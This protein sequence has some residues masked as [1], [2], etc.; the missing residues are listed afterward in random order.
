MAC[1]FL[2][3]ASLAQVQEQFWRM[4]VRPNLGFEYFQR[5]VDLFS[6]DPDKEE[7]IKDEVS[8]KLKS[9]FI[10]L[11]IGVELQEGFYLAPILGY[12]V[13]NHGDLMFRRLP[14][15]VELGVGGISGVLFGGEIEKRLLTLRDVELGL[16]GQFVYY[17]GKEETWDVPGL[18]VEGDVTG[19][20]FWLRGLVGPFLIYR[21][22]YDF[23]PY[24]RLCYSRHWGKFKLEQKIG[25]LNR[26]EEKK[27]IGKSQISL[28]LG[29]SYEITPAFHVSGE[30]IFMPYK[31][32]V[33]SGLAVKV[34]YAF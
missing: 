14:F 12:S 27:M 10:T 5:E 29:A 3:S 4:T 8:T 32:G 11:N 23:S 25:D 7:W 2:A 17:L 30:A 15:S 18:S 26:N 28:F 9:Y 22:F 34:A 24:L 31:K 16:F 13:S 21:G 6:F 20:P 1:L 33:D 19:K